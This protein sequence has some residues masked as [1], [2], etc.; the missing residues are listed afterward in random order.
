M[1][2]L[3]EELFAATSLNL[4]EQR[5]RLQQRKPRLSKSRNHFSPSTVFALDAT[6]NTMPKS[7]RTL[8]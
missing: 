4:S 3:R 2:H 8:E 5:E 1:E 7:G 6:T